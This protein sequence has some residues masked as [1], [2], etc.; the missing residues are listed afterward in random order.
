MKNS[1]LPTQKTPNKSNPPLYSQIIEEVL[2]LTYPSY[3]N[4]FY[5]KKEEL[6]RYIFD[7]FFN[8]DETVLVA[9]EGFT[10]V[11]TAH[12]LQGF[13][14]LVQKH[15]LAS[16]DEF[17]DYMILKKNASFFKLSRIL[18]DHEILTEEEK[19]SIIGGKRWNMPFTIFNLYRYHRELLTA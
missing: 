5:H 16:F 2:S 15:Q 10:N 9:I 19:D 6:Y 17:D 3:Q 18:A 12:H 11:A 7:Y 13:K 4:F 8:D 14:V 1:L